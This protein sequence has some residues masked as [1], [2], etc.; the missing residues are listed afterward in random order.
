VYNIADLHCLLV[1][2]QAHI[3]QRPELVNESNRLKSLEFRAMTHA[4]VTL[5][6]SAVEEEIIRRE[7]PGISVLTVPWAMSVR[8]DSPA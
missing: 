3:Q 7:L 6:H 4:D 5:K 1:L 8:S 2:R